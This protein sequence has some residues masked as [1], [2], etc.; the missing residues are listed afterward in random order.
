MLAALQL[1]YPPCNLVQITWI[2]MK[3]ASD[4]HGFHDL[5]IR[6][7]EGTAVSASWPICVFWL[8]VGFITL[9]LWVLHLILLVFLFFFLCS[10]INTCLGKTGLKETV[11]RYNCSVTIFQCVVCV[12]CSLNLTDNVSLDVW[13]KDLEQAYWVRWELTV[14]GVI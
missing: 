3:F 10:F 4:I 6:A 7:W 2:A 14:S 8:S 9:G 12:K 1:L 5:E 11:F 13:S